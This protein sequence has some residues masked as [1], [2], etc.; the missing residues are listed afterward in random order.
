MTPTNP[1]LTSTST[2]KDDKIGKFNDIIKEA[3]EREVSCKGAGRKNSS[4]L[5]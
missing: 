1:V 4:N 2:T 3:K 5:V